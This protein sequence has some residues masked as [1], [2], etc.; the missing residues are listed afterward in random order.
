[1]LGNGH[2]SLSV[3]VD[4]E[5][6]RSNHHAQIVGEVAKGENLDSWTLMEARF[7]YSTC[8]ES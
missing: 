8:I 7:F 4:A 2:T 1:M 5:G 3:V 6:N